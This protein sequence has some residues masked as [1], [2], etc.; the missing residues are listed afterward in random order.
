MGSAIQNNCCSL[1]STRTTSAAPFQPSLIP[2]APSSS[3]P[4]TTPSS[5]NLLV[6]L[7]MVAAA[8][9]R[10]LNTAKSKKAARRVSVAIR[11]GIPF[12][13]GEVVTCTEVSRKVKNH[14][15]TKSTKVLVAVAPSG[16]LDPAPPSPSD[17]DAP[18][19]SSKLARKGP[20]RSA[21]VSPL[22]S[23]FLL[24]N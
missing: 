1:G 15:L 9:G 23:L 3:L 5:P 2:G 16:P 11:Q 12:N 6:V 10:K 7:T 8:Q 20:S 24:S 14:L 22:F 18:P 21:A 17:Q 4:L 13:K 19:T